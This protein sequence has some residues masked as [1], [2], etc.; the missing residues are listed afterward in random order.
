MADQSD[1]SFG[2]AFIDVTL[3]FTSSEMPSEDLKEARERKTDGHSER[4]ER[5][6]ESNI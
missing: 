4:R 1:S 6:G 2:E 3:H 5:E